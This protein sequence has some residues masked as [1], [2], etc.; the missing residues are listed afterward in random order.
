MG[1]INKSIKIESDFI[2][3]YDIGGDTG[4]TDY[5]YKRYT[6]TTSRGSLL[7]Q[8]RGLGIKTI[9]LKS[10]KQFIGQAKQL[11]VYTNPRLHDNKGKIKVP[12]EKALEIYPNNLA[13]KYYDET[14]K[15]SIKYLQV[16]TRRFKIMMSECG[17]GEELKNKVDTVE[18]LERDLNYNIMRPIYSIDYISDGRIIL[19]TDFNTI[20]RLD[21]L[22]FQDIMKKEEVIQEIKE[23][24]IKYGI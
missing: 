11:V 23:A 5:L 24:I 10:A 22:G 13:S 9:E 1:E 2:D 20:Q 7:K 8:L 4:N 16:G 12:I 3:Y 17:K 15:R 19:A 6:D 21:K 14:N 18:E